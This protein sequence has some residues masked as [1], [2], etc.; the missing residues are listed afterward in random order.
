MLVATKKRRALIVL[1]LALILPCLAAAWALVNLNPIVVSMAEAR[2]RQL[3]V[4]AINSAVNEVI[5]GSFAY[6][7]FVRVTLDA[8]GQVAM[9]K[10]NTILMNDLASKSALVAQRNLQALEDEGVRLPL[11]A[12]LGVKLFGGSGPSIR[13]SV[14]PVGSV[15]TRFVTAFESAGINQTR[16][17]IS[18][19][20]SILMRLIVP[21]GAASVT[22]AA[23]V[24]VAESII[25]GNVPDSYV[26]VPNTDAMLN[27][28]PD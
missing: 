10:A 27:L 4:E 7:D 13:V 16:H 24:P 12:A 21:T 23:Y 20:A 26:N 1:A 25:V 28:I 9:L 18:L 14:V 15:T 5:A 17:E 2:A 22:V 6:E 11:G 19:E 3:A 8:A